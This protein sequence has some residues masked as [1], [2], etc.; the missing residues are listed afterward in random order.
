M[1]GIWKRPPNNALDQ[2]FARWRALSRY[3]V[4]HPWPSTGPTNVKLVPMKYLARI[5]SLTGPTTGWE[6]GDRLRAEVQDPSDPR[7][8][9]LLGEFRSYGDADRAIRSWQAEH[10]GPESCD[11]QGVSYV[12]PD[13][14]DFEN[15]RFNPREKAFR[16]YWEPVLLGGIPMGRCPSLE[17]QRFVIR[18]RAD[19][20]WLDAPWLLMEKIPPHVKRSE[21]ID[22]LE[23]AGFASRY[24]DEFGSEG[25][26]LW[27]VAL[28]RDSMW[29]G[30]S[31]DTAQCSRLKWDEL[32]ALPRLGE[33]RECQC[34]CGEMFEVPLTGSRSGRKFANRECRL[35]TGAVPDLSAFRERANEGDAPLK[36]VPDHCANCGVSLPSSILGL[37]CSQLCSQTAEWVRYARR[38]MR[39]GRV[40]D[41]EVRYALRVRLAHILAG[42]YAKDERRLD[43]EVRRAVVARDNGR[44]RLCGAEGTEIDHIAGDSWDLANLRLLCHACHRSKHEE[45]LVPS[46]P[47]KVLEARALWSRVE[48]TPP[49]RLCDDESSWEREHRRLRSERRQRL[50]RPLCVR[51]D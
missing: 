6:P 35:R 17:P 37:Y 20:E 43:P 29:Q 1:E 4:V 26:L 14:R 45:M 2:L 22:A 16:Q 5:T 21:V 39:D 46:P 38:V 42:G 27:G 10:H 3:P 41:D 18:G 40:N 24:G 44:C 51:H 36:F 47:E 7:K 8:P 9:M 50:S 11:G 25:K 48:V 19:R 31:L 28:T 32:L 30:E 23:F 15:P 49:R 34:G 33:Q 12:V 13:A